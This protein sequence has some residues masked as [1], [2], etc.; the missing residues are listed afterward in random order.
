MEGAI[1]SADPTFH[2]MT[3]RRA[4]GSDLRHARRAEVR[5]ALLRELRR[6]KSQPGLES[7]A[8]RAQL[9]DD[10][11]A[12]SAFMARHG[13]Q[14]VTAVARA[15]VEAWRA[16]LWRGESDWTARGSDGA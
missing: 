3:V 1:V 12:D 6:H 8:D 15:V 11:M 7:T 2:G 16:G 14:L 4:G 10:A 13:G 5:E 9:A